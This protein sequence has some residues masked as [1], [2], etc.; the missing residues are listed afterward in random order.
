MSDQVDARG[1]SRFDDLPEYPSTKAV[2]EYRTA[3]PPLSPLG[4][5]LVAGMLGGALGLLFSAGNAV[6]LAGGF[7]VFGL[8]GLAVGYALFDHAAVPGQSPEPTTGVPVQSGAI[9]SGRRT[10]SKRTKK[11]AVVC[12]CLLG[13]VLLWQ[14]PLLDGMA[15][16]FSERR[17]LAAGARWVRPGMTQAQVPRLLGAPQLPAPHAAVGDE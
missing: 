8:L 12:S 7:V 13:V 15:G 11:G 2:P 4:W 9:A 3:T 1:G 5:A 16:I 14:P 10:V 17:A 6:D